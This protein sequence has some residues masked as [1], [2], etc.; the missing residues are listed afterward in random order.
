[1][2][3]SYIKPL[4][5]YIRMFKLYAQKGVIVPVR[6]KWGH[7]NLSLYMP[8]I[9]KRNRETYCRLYAQHLKTA[10]SKRMT[11]ILPASFFQA[12]I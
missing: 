5:A 10:V 11:G 4:S 9:R 7:R 6:L 3:C 1:M 2:K 12:L 8:V